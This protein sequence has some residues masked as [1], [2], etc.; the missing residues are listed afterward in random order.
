M[1]KSAI[2]K[3]L[4]PRRR[5]ESVYQG[6]T[7]VYEGHPAKAVCILPTVEIYI[8]WPRFTT[9]AAQDTDRNLALSPMAMHELEHT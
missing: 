8:F 7:C 2:M 4:H 3:E 9:E 1:G 5:H 6:G